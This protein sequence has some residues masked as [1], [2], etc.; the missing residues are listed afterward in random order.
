[1]CRGV[2]ATATSARIRTKADARGNHRVLTRVPRE[3]T[4]SDPLAFVWNM[5]SGLCFQTDGRAGVR[6]KNIVLLHH[7]VVPAFA[8]L[9]PHCAPR[10]PGWSGQRAQSAGASS[11]EMLRPQIHRPLDA[12]H[13]DVVNLA[14]EALQL[15]HRHV[16]C[17]ALRHVVRCR[18]YA[19][20]CMRWLSGATVR[21]RGPSLSRYPQRCP[22]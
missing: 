4:R 10:G 7:D 21:W 20:H 18:L 8:L 22:S 9:Y 6:S 16:V 17:C 11:G 5:L 1:M 13:F 2:V 3:G 12:A 19:V 14:H 15:R